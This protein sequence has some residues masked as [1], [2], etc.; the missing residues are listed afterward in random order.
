MRLST[1]SAGHVAGF[2]VALLVVAGCAPPSA[3]VASTAN[4]APD[5]KTGAP[6]SGSLDACAL[7]PLAVAESAIDSK[8]TLST[9][10]VPGGP[11]CLYGAANPNDSPYSVDLDVSPAQADSLATER[12]GYAQPNVEIADETGFGPGAFSALNVTS[13]SID[14]VK[15]GVLHDIT[16]TAPPFPPDAIPA[17]AQF[18]QRGAQAIAKRL[19]TP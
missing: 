12:E 19:C 15:G 5:A 7:L 16:V 9:S 13:A 14:C 2:A 10:S 17:N 8:V 6:G 11:E 1:V 4:S 18:A 3:G